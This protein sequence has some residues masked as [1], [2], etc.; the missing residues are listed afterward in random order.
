VAPGG[1]TGASGQTRRRSEKGRRKG[2]SGEGEGA[3]QEEGRRGRRRKKGRETEAEE[4]ERGGGG[5]RRGSA[6]EA[7]RGARRRRSE[8]TVMQA[9]AGNRDKKQKT[10]GMRRFAT[11]PFSFC[12]GSKRRNSLLVFKI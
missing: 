8:R 7:R 12:C 10:K 5:A 4:E 11:H 6:E 1:S 3:R 9:N 2:R